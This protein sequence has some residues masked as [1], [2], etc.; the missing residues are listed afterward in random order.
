MTDGNLKETN[1]RKFLARSNLKKLHCHLSILVHLLEQFSSPSAHRSINLDLHPNEIRVSGSYNHAMSQQQIRANHVAGLPF[2][3]SELPGLNNQKSGLGENFNNSYNGRS[4][5]PPSPKTKLKIEQQQQQQ[6]AKMAA[7]GMNNLTQLAQ[8]RMSSLG[9]NIGIPG[10][11]PGYPSPIARPPAS[12]IDETG[13][14]QFIKKGHGNALCVCWHFTDSFL[15][16][17]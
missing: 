8:L 14:F 15:N 3:K 6:Q 5:G 11:T 13:Y 16:V 17:E 2:I 1:I 9:Y 10:V 12:K 4:N 7:A